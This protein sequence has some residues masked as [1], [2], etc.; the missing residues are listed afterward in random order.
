MLSIDTCD[1]VDC[2]SG[3]KRGRGKARSAHRLQGALEFRPGGDLQH[4]ELVSAARA[5]LSSGAT[6][7]VPGSSYIVLP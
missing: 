5:K 2:L 7:R 4:P 6:G 1:P 3:A